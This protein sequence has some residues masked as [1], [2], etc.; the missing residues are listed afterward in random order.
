MA[1]RR[2][3]DCRLGGRLGSGPTRGEHRLP[4]EAKGAFSRDLNT[5]ALALSLRRPSD[6]DVM[7]RSARHIIVLYERSRQGDEA[8]RKAA[9]I[10]TRT[11][12]RLTLV[13]VAVT[14]R[15]N[16]GCCD[17][18]SAYWNRVVQEL[19][20]D[21]L[22]RAKRV[23]DPSLVV[24]ARVIAGPSISG[25]V[26]DEAQ[27]CGAD[28]LVLPAHRSIWSWSRR[29]RTREMRRNMPSSIALIT[30]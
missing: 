15:V 5:G 23:L 30:S 2:R 11:G 27:R 10:A 12:A 4:W 29:R 25:A 21:D 13:A 6:S 17:L 14:E 24:E 7:Q 9:N 1:T 28:M 16:S 8:I 3:D 19:A 22:V 20:A 26:A 18:R